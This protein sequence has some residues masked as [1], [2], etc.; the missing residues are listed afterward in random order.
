MVVTLAFG[1]LA[2]LTR[3]RGLLEFERRKL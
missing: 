3:K 1:L 2:M